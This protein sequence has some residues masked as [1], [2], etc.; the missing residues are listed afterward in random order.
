M[1]CANQ[2]MTRRGINR[3]IGDLSFRCSTTIPAIRCVLMAG[4]NDHQNFASYSE[5]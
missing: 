1:H 2:L 5:R 4:S 3:R